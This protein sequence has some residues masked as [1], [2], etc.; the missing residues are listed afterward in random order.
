MNS[1]LNYPVKATLSG[2]KKDEQ[3]LENYALVKLL[4]LSDKPA[5]SVSY[6][7]S[8]M[9]SQE[10]EPVSLQGA[11]EEINLLPDESIELS[12]PL[13][14]YPDDVSLEI[15][16]TDVSFAEADTSKE[17]ADEDSTYIDSEAIVLDDEESETIVLDGE[18]SEPVVLDD[19]DKAE[20]LK[21]KAKKEARKV[22][23]KKLA[24]FS[25]RALLVLVCLAVLLAI[26]SVIYRFVMIG[27]ANKHL[28]D[29][30]YMKAYELFDAVGSDS[31]AKTTEEVKGN[32][33]SN[34]MHEGFLAEDDKYLYYLDVNLNIHVENKETKET[35]NTEISGT[36]LNAIGGMLYYLTSEGAVFKL[37]PETFETWPVEVAEGFTPHRLLNVIGNSF[38]CLAYDTETTDHIEQ[39]APY[40]YKFKEGGK[41]EKILDAQVLYYVVYKGDIYFSD[42]NDET[43]S[44]YVLDKKGNEPKKIIEGPVAQFEIIDDVIY[45]LDY[46][47]PSTSTDGVPVLK[48]NAT[49]LDGNFIKTVSGDKK[50]LRFTVADG[51]IYFLEYLTDTTKLL[52]VPL[53]G[54]DI[55]T[56]SE[57]SYYLINTLG[58]TAVGFSLEG[59]MDKI[60]L[61]TGETTP[62][63]NAIVTE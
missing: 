15:E 2:I 42:Y 21:F 43:S 25:I 49:D 3:T 51:K 48:I 33:T 34:L 13:S 56:I 55:T 6:K 10:S 38:Y 4:N 16:L 50:V 19:E 41:P 46:T 35:K 47:I 29:G 44:V 26:V 57:K 23:K 11:F 39:S 30:N 37:D 54:G 18:D 22:A 40:L 31:V 24:K 14:E 36:N 60:D 59:S 28:K 63:G 12:I 32:T 61:T 27:I 8:I 20:F 52:S 7:I 45:Y 5:N 62:I 17:P 1:D 9:I 53:D 58:N